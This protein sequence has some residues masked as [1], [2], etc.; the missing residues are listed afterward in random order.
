MI[1]K[2]DGNNADAIRDDKDE[3][4]DFA[5]EEGFELFDIQDFIVEHYQNGKSFEEN[6]KTLKWYVETE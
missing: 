6:L 4:E 2:K 1:N 3:F 5:L